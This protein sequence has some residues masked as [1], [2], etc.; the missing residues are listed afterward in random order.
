[1]N[2]FRLFYDQLK[3]SWSKK[4]SLQLTTLLV[5]TG[6]FLV[7]SLT[8]LLLSNFFSVVNSFGEKLEVSVY[9]TDQS[10]EEDKSKINKLIKDSNLFSDIKF[11]DK[12]EALIEFKNAMKEHLPSFLLEEKS[13][14]PLPSSYALKIKNG[15]ATEAGLAKINLFADQLKQQV[16]VE[17][18][19]Y[20]Q[21]WAVKYASFLKTYK[22]LSLGVI[23]FILLSIVLIIGNSIKSSLSQRRKEI[24]VLELVGASRLYIRMPFIMEGAFMGVVASGLSILISYLIYNW[25]INVAKNNMGVLINLNSLH[26]HSALLVLLLCIAGG[27]VG[28]IGATVCIKRMNSGWSA[29]NE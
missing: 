9:L 25:I 29:V 11:V 28:A 3:Y 10:V 12:K 7:L 4:L 16:G 24:E 8:T 15:F 5:L 26:F 17:D 1:M 20:G 22:A 2:Y 19:S 13:I 6:S 27:F 21:A 18:V 23:I 14:N